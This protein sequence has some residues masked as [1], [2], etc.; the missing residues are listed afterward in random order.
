MVYAAVDAR[1]PDALTDAT[2]PSVPPVAVLPERVPSAAAIT[3]KGSGTS[4][5][6]ATELV[7]E[8]RGI[9]EMSR[10]PRPQAPAD[11]LGEKRRRWSVLTRR[12]CGRTGPWVAPRVGVVGSWPR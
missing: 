5:R 10:C 4:I 7:C 12:E 11:S 8:M 2:G 1:R 6:T 3:R 9:G